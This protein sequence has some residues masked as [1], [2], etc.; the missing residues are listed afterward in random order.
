MR[1]PLQRLVGGRIEAEIQFCGREPSANIPSCTIADSDVINAPEPEL[2]PP[3]LLL[4][5]FPPSQSS[6]ALSTLVLTI[7]IIHGP[8]SLPHVL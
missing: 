3:G 2:R 6:R 4:F 8:F 1:A 5:L 7:I